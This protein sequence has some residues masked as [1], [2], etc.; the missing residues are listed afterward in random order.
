MKKI[1]T[2]H[3]VQILTKMSNNAVRKIGATRLAPRLE[4]LGIMV[5]DVSGRGKSIT[6]DVNLTDTFW[7]MFML[8]IKIDKEANCSILTEYLSMLIQGEGTISTTGGSYVPFVR[9]IA[10]SLAQHHDI[11]ISEAENFIKRTNAVLDRYEFRYKD[12]SIKTY[13]VIMNGEW[14][15]GEGINRY[16]SVLKDEWRN[17]FEE[18]I[19]RKYP[20]CNRKKGDSIRI[21]AMCIVFRQQLEYKY[22]LDHIRTFKAKTISREFVDFGNQ[23]RALCANGESIEGV[24]QYRDNYLTK[25]L[26]GIKLEKQREKERKQ[27][28][29]ESLLR[30]M[31]EEGEEKVVEEKIGLLTN[32]D[33]PSM[34]DMYL[35]SQRYSLD[36]LI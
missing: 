9:E 13:R 14:I 10:Q 16:D 33:I 3:D 2:V 34:E 21:N 11:K 4:K 7:S 19:N 31:F 24:V 6:Y 30:E 1:L 28:E 15:T 25:R 32:M 17:F 36:E 27:A 29:M 35:T 12:P 22:C 23:L 20:L 18:R 8:N 26:Q 5:L